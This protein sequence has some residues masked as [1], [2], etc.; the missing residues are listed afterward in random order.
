MILK[1]KQQP[2]IQKQNKKPEMKYYESNK[3]QKWVITEDALSRL[4]QWK[5]VKLKKYK[6]NVCGEGL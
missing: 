2:R 5:G 1:K 3:N 6:A 4:N